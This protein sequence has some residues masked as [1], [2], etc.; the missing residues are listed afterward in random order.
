MLKIH[1]PFLVFLSFFGFL[2]QFAV[3][4]QAICMREL[5]R[6]TNHLTQLKNDLKTG[7]ATAI[8]KQINKDIDLELA[9]TRNL[10]YLRCLIMVL[11]QWLYANSVN[12]YNYHTV[13]IGYRLKISISSMIYRKT[14]KLSKSAFAS[15]SIGQIQTLLSGDMNRLET[16]FY[17]VAYPFIGIILSVVTI[18]VLWPYL[19]WF[20]LV[21]MLVLALIIPVQSYIGKVFSYMRTKA[22]Y[23]CDERMK[24]MN[25][26]I[27]AIRVIKMYC[28]ENE[29]AQKIS[30]ARKN[31]I[32]KIRN[33]LYL[34]SCNM[35]MFYTGAKVIIYATLV[36]YVLFSDA[37]NL[38][39]F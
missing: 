33:C 21:G 16:I 1:G 24:Q 9:S 3:L 37:G 38:F 17:L 32:N 8:E 26:F 31:E 18:Y 27:P 25:E 36:C 20:T 14:L 13:L 35:A 5:I 7:N 4:Y 30:K 39:L 11:L 15:T 12:I 22:A 34:F 23:C 6:E 29:F 2:G 10:I 28:W 19:G